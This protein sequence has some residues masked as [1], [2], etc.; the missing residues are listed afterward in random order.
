MRAVPALVLALWALLPS[1]ALTME[2][3]WSDSATG[4]AIAGFDPVSFFTAAKPVAGL[5]DH[6]YVWRDATWRF[7]NMANL[8]AFRRDPKIYAPQFGGLGAF[9]LARGYRTAG[10]PRVWLVADGRLYFFFSAENRLKW[11]QA[12]ETWHQKATENWQ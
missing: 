1:K 5:S 2:R 3:F 6:E 10:N 11:L 9:A 8:A 4:L 12:S 7:A